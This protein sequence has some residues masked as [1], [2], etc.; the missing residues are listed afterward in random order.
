MP[1][2][3]VIAALYREPRWATATQRQASASSIR[4]VTR[5][6]K[7]DAVAALYKEKLR[8]YLGFPQATTPYAAK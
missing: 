7:H 6:R 4:R 2:V 8:L 3:F 5:D 1:A